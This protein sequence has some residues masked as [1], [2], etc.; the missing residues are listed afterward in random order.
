MAP[1]MGQT[2]TSIAHHGATAHHAT[3]HHGTAAG[4]GP[5]PVVPR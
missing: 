1:V 3:A 2:R 5:I 4:G